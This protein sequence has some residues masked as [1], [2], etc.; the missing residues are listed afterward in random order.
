MSENNKQFVRIRG[1]R[2]AYVERGAGPTLV[3]LHGNPTS[4]FLWR[5]LIAPLSARYRCL[6]PDLIGMG[7]S[8][9]LPEIGKVAYGFAAHQTFLDAWFDAVVPREPVVLVV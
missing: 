3:F 7:D 8:D 5:N 1:Q 4:S 6:A 9:K 2:M